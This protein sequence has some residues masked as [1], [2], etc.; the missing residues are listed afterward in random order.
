MVRVFISGAGA[1]DDIADAGRVA[2]GV[3]GD[4]TAFDISADE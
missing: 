1:V 2:Y 4:H 3:H